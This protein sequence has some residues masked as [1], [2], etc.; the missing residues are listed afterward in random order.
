[1]KK[2]LTVLTIVLLSGCAS[3]S[4]QGER[5]NKGKPEPVLGMSKEE[6]QKSWGKPKRV[7]ITPGGETWQYDDAELALI[8][9]NFG[10]RPQFFLFTF[11][12]DGKLVDYAIT[13]HD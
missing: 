3:N 2:L 12:K 5:P 1:M 9:F 11:D 6:I 8:P 4:N 13:K 10:F 7:T